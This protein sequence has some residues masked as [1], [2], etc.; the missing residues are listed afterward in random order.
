[1]YLPGLLAVLALCGWTLSSRRRR[2]RWLIPTLLVLLIYGYNFGNNL[3]VAIIHSLDVGRYIDNQFAYTLLACSLGVVFVGEVLRD[4]AVR[5]FEASGWSEFFRFRPSSG[6]AAFLPLLPRLVPSAKPPS[7]GLLL[8][9][10]ASSEANARLEKECREAFPGAPLQ[11]AN[12]A[13]DT[14]PECDGNAFPGINDCLSEIGTDLVLLADASRAYSAEML[15]ASWQSYLDAPADLMI[16][17]LPA[18]AGL[19]LSSD[20]RGSWYFKGILRWVFD[21]E[22]AEVLSG[23][24]LLSRRFYGNILLCSQRE[25]LP[26]ELV[27]HAMSGGFSTRKFPLLP[28]PTAFDE[29]PLPEIGRDPRY[30]WWTLGSLLMLGFDF[31]PMRL[32]RAFAV[33]F[34]LLGVLIGYSPLHH[35]GDNHQH[36]SRAVQT[37]LAG[38]MLVAALLSLQA[39]VILES[40]LRHDR[41]ERQLRIRRLHGNTAEKLATD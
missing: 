6:R 35:L 20:P 25:I 7:L 31:Q 28:L 38:S 5:A 12:F 24:H 1:M 34:L 30:S 16:G 17:A 26:L 36:F 39:G 9:H 2:R 13:S 29:T 18:S 10:S 33:G 14:V 32:L 15:R 27:L 37:A 3:T 19:S 22:P 21:W 11:A 23:P 4:A 8:I 41:K 40:R